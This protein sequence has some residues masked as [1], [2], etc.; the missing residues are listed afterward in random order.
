MP[1]A[2]TT[3]AKPA[4]EKKKPP[5]AAP[6]PPKDNP[7][8]AEEQAAPERAVVYTSVEAEVCVGDKAITEKMA[9]QLLGWETEKEYQVRM[10]AANPGT[11]A[12]AWTYGEVYMLKDE[13]GNKVRCWHNLDNRPFD[14]VWSRGLAQSILRFGWAGPTTIPGETVNGSTVVISRTGKVESG[15]H[16]L[17]GLILAWQM[18]WKD[19][20]RYPQWEGVGRKDESFGFVETGPII[21]T[22]VITGIS[23][24]PRVLMTVDNCKPRSEADV[25]YTSELFRKLIPSDRRE[26]SRMLASAVDFLWKRTDTKGYKTHTEVV[27]FVDRHPKLLKCIEHLFTE[28]SSKGGRLIS[29]LRIPVGQA[30]GMCYL[31]GCSRGTT[32]G[33]LYRNGVPPQERGLDWTAWDDAKKFWAS[34]GASE[35]FNAVRTALGRLVDSTPDSE[36]NVGLG[37]RSPEKLAILAKAWEHYASGNKAFTDL[38]LEEGGAL[39]LNYVDTDPKGNKLPNGQVRLLD[40]ADFGGIDNSETSKMVTAEPP[41]PNPEELKAAK[42][43]ERQQR[44]KEITDRL[45]AMR[46]QAPS[47]KPKS[48]VK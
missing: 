46:T 7:A 48:E 8:K 4:V 1:A 13:E 18:W 35:D 32:D 16:S 12:E 10:T 24:D 26:C 2:P 47:A 45:K 38:D 28:N 11:K 27:A 15:Q 6:P 42:E 14:E 3:T 41:P 39:Y 25:F 40:I 31:M 29:A 5:K 44:A 22:I 9:K 36:D 34:I 37:G 30:A 20:K 19:R 21:E 23:E 43:A 33:D 17:V